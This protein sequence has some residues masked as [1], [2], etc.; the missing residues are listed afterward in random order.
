MANSLLSLEIED[1]ETNERWCGEF[2]SQYIEDITLKAGNFKKF[3]TFVKMVCS[4]FSKDNES[5]FMDILTGS[6]LETLKARKQGGASKP[7]PTSA[8]PYA[9]KRYVIL[10]YSGEFDRVHYPLPLAFESQPNA[11]SLQ[12]TVRRLR[13]RLAERSD[14]RDGLAEIG[15]DKDVRQIIANLRQENTELRHRLRQAESRSKV[16]ATGGLNGPLIPSQAAALNELTSANGKLRRQVDALRKELADATSLH[17]KQRLESLKEINKWKLRVGAAARDRLEFYSRDATSKSPSPAGRDSGKRDDPLRSRVSQRDSERSASRPWDN[18]PHIPQVGFASRRSNTPPQPSGP[19]QKTS[20]SSV[21]SLSPATL[22]RVRAVSRGTPTIPPRAP[23]PSRSSERKVPI[24]SSSAP[25]QER[26]RSVSPSFAPSQRY[27]SSVGGRFD[28]T[29][30]Q[31]QRL[32][33]HALKDGSR[34]FNAGGRRPNLDVDKDSPSSGRRYRTTRESGYSSN[35]SGG[36]SSRRSAGSKSPKSSRKRGRRPASK[37]SHPPS[38]SEDDRAARR[39]SREVKARQAR[40]GIAER[41]LIESPSAPAASTARAEAVTASIPASPI[42]FPFVDSSQE[43]APINISPKKHPSSPSR[44]STVAKSP[45]SSPSKPARN[46][47]SAAAA[48]QALRISKD[49]VSSSARSSISS[50]RASLDKA[51]SSLVAAASTHGS[52]LRV[53]A[54]KGERK[55]DEIS[56]IDRR[57]QAL[58]SYLDNARYARHFTASVS[59]Y[60]FTHASDSFSSFPGWACKSTG[61]KRRNE[62]SDSF[63]GQGYAANARPMSR[64]TVRSGSH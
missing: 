53:S 64:N 32:E 16:G 61:Q 17:E 46:F 11:D 49:S 60:S 7:P 26:P 33:R 12:R 30:Y 24:R 14:Q 27:S 9:G 62:C 59:P 10:T 58:Q 21:S 28:P 45:S 5:V 38:D 34:P 6:D 13:G 44:S 36:Y 48:T 63:F 23:K 52:P 4:G 54:L 55:D 20:R 57:I 42:P 1:T 22:A 47:L 37:Q 3:T 39:P 43:R 31:Q 50:P 15:A 25:S 41:S 18:R 2:T 51:L 19:P 35:E 29:L 40:R 56:E 8:A